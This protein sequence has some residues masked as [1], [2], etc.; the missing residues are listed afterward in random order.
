MSRAHSSGQSFRV[1]ASVVIPSCVCAAAIIRK[2]KWSV[3]SRARRCVVAT[4]MLNGLES[5]RNPLSR[6][7]T[8]RLRTPSAPRIEK[9]VIHG[10]IIPLEMRL[11]YSAPR[12][13]G[14]YT[15]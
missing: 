11:A 4:M 9:I 15:A 2:N 8:H 5:F 13:D 7:A 6:T 1:Y 3:A 14:R 12:T 10:E